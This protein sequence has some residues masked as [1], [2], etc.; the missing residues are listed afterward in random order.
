[1]Y[2]RYVVELVFH[3]LR[4]V[5]RV[6]QPGPDR[7]VGKIQEYRTRVCRSLVH[8]LPTGVGTRCVLT[9]GIDWILVGGVEATPRKQDWYFSQERH[10]YEFICMYVK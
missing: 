5:C 7:I 8:T 6:P 2:I 10:M 9:A 1:M 4:S 3:T